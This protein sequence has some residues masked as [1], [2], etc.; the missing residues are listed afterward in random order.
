MKDMKAGSGWTVSATRYRLIC[1][2]GLAA[3]LSA[4]GG[5]GDSQTQPAAQDKAVQ[6]S[7]MSGALDPLQES[8]SIDGVQAFSDQAVSDAALRSVMRCADVMLSQAVLDLGDQML[9]ALRDAAEFSNPALLQPDQ[10]A[11]SQRSQSLV[12]GIA[13]FLGALS[14]DDAACARS[15]WTLGD[16]GTVLGAFDGGPLEPL[17]RTLGPALE[18]AALRSTEG[19]VDIA[20]FSAMLDDLDVAMQ[21]AMPQLAP[22]V[23]DTPVIGGAL[24]SLA[25]ALNQAATLYR[26]ALVFD[27]SDV[28]ASL[29]AFIAAVT[30]NV[31][32]E[33][34]PVAALEK[35][36]P[37]AIAGLGI[38]SAQIQ[39]DADQASA[40]IVAKASSGAPLEDLLWTVGN[41]TRPLATQLL[42]VL[43]PAILTPLLGNVAA[44]VL[45]MVLRLAVN[46]L[47]GLLGSIL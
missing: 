42:L 10:T 38:G 9:S 35:Q 44:P 43:V 39:E 2:I 30:G 20:A 40:E 13:G 26:A 19:S 8:L 33:L 17:T 29:E 3:V 21:G 47:S 7:P 1:V 12:V 41:L 5:S 22:E 15:Q 32:T 18:R 6:A 24:Q 45:D 27:E 25:E 37:Q 16:I 34:V 46:L 14:G 28:G 11:L 4:C 36:A 23:S 31:L